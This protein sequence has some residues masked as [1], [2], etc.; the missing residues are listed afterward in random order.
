MPNLLQ[1]DQI[2]SS[3]VFV[4][5]LKMSCLVSPLRGDLR[6]KHRIAQD[7]AVWSPLPRVGSGGLEKVCPPGAQH[8]L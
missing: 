8:L 2:S 3:M 5:A 1:G 6:E 7:E 4:A